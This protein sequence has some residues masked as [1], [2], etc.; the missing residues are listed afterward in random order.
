MLYNAVVA[1]IKYTESKMVCI[2]WYIHCIYA[3][4]PR[5]E[6]VI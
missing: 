5:N 2:T 3:A 6:C 1:G 4:E